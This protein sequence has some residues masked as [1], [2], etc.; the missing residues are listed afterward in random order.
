[1]KNTRKKRSAKTLSYTPMARLVQI[2]NA[3]DADGEPRVALELPPRPGSVSRRPILMMFTTM[4]AA[5]AS[6]RTLEAAQ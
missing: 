1:V 2:P 6:K 4:A 3:H 5:L